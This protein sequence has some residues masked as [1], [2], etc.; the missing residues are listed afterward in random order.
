MDGGS[1][2]ARF[3]TRTADDPPSTPA[4]REIAAEQ[5]YV[6]RVYERVEQM[7]DQARLLAAEGRARGMISDTGVK[8]DDEAGFFERDVLVHHASRRIATLNAEHGGLVFGR[9]D[10]HDSRVDYIGRL[11]VLDEDYDPLV[12]DWRAPA[13][14]VF[15]QATGAAPMGVVRRRVLHCV[16]GRVTGVDDDLLDPKAGNGLVVVGDGALLEALGRARGHQM[17]DIVAT[18]QA[19]QD[20]AIRAPAR[21]ATLISGGPGTGKTVVALH[22][23]AYLLYTDRRRFEGG[24]ILVV[25]PSPG[26]MAYIERVLPSLGE[27]SVSLRP[28]GGV[29]DAENATRHDA[30][31]VAAIKGSLRMCT[32][33]ARAARDAVPGAPT[34]LRLWHEGEAL[35]VSERQLAGARRRALSAGVRRN[36]ARRRAIR[37]LSTALWRVSSR[38]QAITRAEFDETLRENGE[39]ADFVRR[40]WPA[41]LPREVLGWL[42]VP[43]RLARYA[44]GLLPTGDVEAL[45]AS[46]RGGVVDDPSVDDVALLDELRVLLS[47]PQEAFRPDA[48]AAFDPS[49]L[50]TAADRQYA[51][52]AALQ[53]PDDHDDYAHVLV[54]E[55]QDLSPM[56]WRMLGRRGTSASWTIVGDRAQSSWPDPDEARAAMDQALGSQPRHRV[57]LETNYRNSAEIFDY[58]SELVR[59]AVP[60][61]DI[62][63]AVRS[64]GH[65]PVHSAVAAAGLDDAIRGTVTDLLDEVGGTVAVIAAAGRRPAIATLLGGLSDDRVAVLSTVDSKG[66]EYDAVLVVDPEE[67]VAESPMGHRL[68]YVA[69]TRATQR[70]ATL[71]T[72]R[73]A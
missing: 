68:L 44:E 1:S 35:R 56:Q 12:I 15:Y 57:H 9:L 8:W 62:P 40:W 39:F 48:E 7:A 65:P 64:T 47:P 31:E 43:E 18:I 17:R 13:A 59:R 27:R 58:A 63:T 11:G 33:L 36:A 72:T 66:L 61:A 54:D 14:A 71:R 23:A 32:V 21:G 70:L 53:R 73:A 6:D 24:G 16:A 34:S 49:E 69:L 45:L 50:T 46:W 42:A 37:S 28:I 3:M 67:I 29:L 10:H 25:G 41:L 30:P 55:A 60:D 19:E 5:R 26:F 51:I 22:R 52:P 4:A 2:E 20:L 38:Q